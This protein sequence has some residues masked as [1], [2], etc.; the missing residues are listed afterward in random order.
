MT[1]AIRLGLILAL[2]VSLSGQERTPLGVTQE[3]QQLL[4]ELRALLEGP[5]IITAPIDAALQGV[6]DVAPAGAVIDLGGREYPIAATLTIDKPITIRNGTLQASTPNL[7]DLVVITGDDVT[8]T[9]LTLRG[10]GSTRRGI[11]ANGR[12]MLFDTIRVERIG[13]KGVESQAVAIWN[14]T[15]LTIRDSFLQAGSTAFLSGG[16]APTVANHIPADLLFERVTF[17][18]DLAWRGQ[19]YGCKTG[20]ELKSARRVIVRDSIV[21]YVWTEGQI[22]YA[23]TLT[24][25]QYGNSPETI[26]EDVLFENLTVRDVGGGVSLYGLT[27]HSDPTRQTLRSRAIRFIGGT[28]T[29]SK[30]Q[31]GGHGVIAMFGKGPDV[32]EFR[33]LTVTADGDAFLRT[34][35]TV[36]VTGLAF[37]D[38][39]VRVTGTYGIFTPLGSRGGAWLATIFPSATFTGN[40]LVNA[41]SAMK[42]ALPSNTYLVE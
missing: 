23:V 24:P 19:G 14:G 16:A 36:P 29:I 26:V 8:L 6:V 39:T 37:Q 13:L 38:N 17:S 7:G 31:Y 25:S 12:R 35:D 32:V 41:P 11:A 27:Q 30:A 10:D 22:G 40:T 4:A 20:F 18:H 28:W 42:T 5:P 9:R 15:G 21:E 33:N 1:T 3:V 34:A 2:S